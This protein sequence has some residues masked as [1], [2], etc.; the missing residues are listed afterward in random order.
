MPTPITFNVLDNK[1][2]APININKRRAEGE[3]IAPQI[4]VSGSG[5]GPDPGERRIIVI[6]SIS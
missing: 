4:L 6:T 3:L 1:Q 5:P 2:Q